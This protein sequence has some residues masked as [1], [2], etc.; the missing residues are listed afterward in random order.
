VFR[1]I[2]RQDQKGNF[3]CHIIIKTLSIKNKKR[4]LKG[5]REKYQNIYKHRPIRITANLL[6]ESL[7]PGGYK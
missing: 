2:T 5:T 3:L 4:T 7:K 1:T 6:A